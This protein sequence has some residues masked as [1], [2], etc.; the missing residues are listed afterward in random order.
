MIYEKNLL[1]LEYPGATNSFCLLLIFPNQQI[2]SRISE[3][4]ESNLQV[5]F[6]WFIN[7][8]K[9]FWTINEAS[10]FMANFRPKPSNNEPLEKL[11]IIRN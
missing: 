1:E 4:L 7:T 5:S 3:S 9:L 11:K 2:D 8:V 6:I 10:V